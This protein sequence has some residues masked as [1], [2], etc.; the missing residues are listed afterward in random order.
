MKLHVHFVMFTELNKDI[1]L[2]KKTDYIR[3]F[4][5]YS[6]T[7]IINKNTHLKSLLFYI[8][9]SF[10]YLPLIS[11]SPNNLFCLFTSFV[12]CS[13][14]KFV[15]NLLRF[16]LVVYMFILYLYLQ[17]FQFD[18]Y[19]YIGEKFSF[20]IFWVVVI[21]RVVFCQDVKCTPSIWLLLCWLSVCAIMFVKIYIRVDF[22]YFNKRYLKLVP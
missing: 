3:I 16:D 5:Y 12:F 6:F 13:F 14:L 22:V 18:D 19:F 15:M 20:C 11:S 2:F 1:L 4:I 7:L 9:S 21:Y 8:Q 10:L 17:S